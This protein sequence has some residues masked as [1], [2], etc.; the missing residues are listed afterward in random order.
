MSTTATQG[1]CRFNPK[2]IR[3]NVKEVG[4]VAVFELLINSGMDKFVFYNSPNPSILQRIWMNNKK[5]S[6]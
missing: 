3:L 5:V 6:F 2:A 1:L 4:S